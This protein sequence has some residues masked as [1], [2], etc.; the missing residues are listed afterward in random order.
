[1]AC[2]VRRFTPNDVTE[3][4]QHQWIAVV[5]DSVGRN[6]FAAFMRL[7]AD[8]GIQMAAGILAKRLLR[9]MSIGFCKQVVI[10]VIIFILPSQQYT[11]HE[12]TINIIPNRSRVYGVMQST[13][14]Q[15]VVPRHQIKQSLRGYL[16]LSDKRL[17]EPYRISDWYTVVQR[18]G[19]GLWFLKRTIVLFED[20]NTQIPNRVFSL[21]IPGLNIE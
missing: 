6:I 10:N 14:Y 19:F 4:L 18:S 1:M 13:T 9:E 2:N 11:F 8:E 20:S 12:L 3:L 15:P 21:R 7:V 5:G 16:L 17:V